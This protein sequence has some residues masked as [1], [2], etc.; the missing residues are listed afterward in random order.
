MKLGFHPLNK[1]QGQ[2]SGDGLVVPIKWE[3]QVSLKTI[4]IREKLKIGFYSWSVLKF[5]DIL[6]E[7]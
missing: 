2:G 7:L 1:E 6:Y 3:M 4:Q 5:L